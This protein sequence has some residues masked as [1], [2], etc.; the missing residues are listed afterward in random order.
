MD[1]MN[2]LM[3]ANHLLNHKYMDI[4]NMKSHK[5]ILKNEIKNEKEYMDQ[6]NKP[7]K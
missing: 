3:T 1:L 6:F 2:Q 7:K 5:E 4:A